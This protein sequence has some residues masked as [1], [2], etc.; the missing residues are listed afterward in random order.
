ME[1]GV[2]TTARS[3]ERHSAVC[4]DD[5]D[6]D[7]DEYEVV[8][9]PVACVKKKSAAGNWAEPKLFLGHTFSI[10]TFGQLV[11]AR[12]CAPEIA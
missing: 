3:L 10:C 9:C 8:A 2:C 6:D 7:E 5:D 4:D 12:D 11:A 1:R